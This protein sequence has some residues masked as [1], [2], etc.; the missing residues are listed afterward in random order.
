MIESV[1]DASTVL[2]WIQSEPGGDVAA[3]AIPSGI[4]SA[5]NVAEVLAKLI[6]KGWAE[7]DAV[8]L[9]QGLEC[10]VVAAD[11]AAAMGAG[12]LHGALRKR[13]VSLGDCFCLALAQE[14]GLPLLTGDR[15][16][17]ALGLDIEVNLIR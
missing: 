12:L 17:A 9:T 15:A 4:M 7:V 2:A 11:R 14:R 8:A 6:G 3:E 13:G 10:A 5:V 16:W 1:L